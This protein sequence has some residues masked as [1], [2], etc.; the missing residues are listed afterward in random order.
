MKQTTPCLSTLGRKRKPE[1]ECRTLPTD[2]H[3]ALPRTSLQD[4]SV[5]Q[6]RHDFRTMVTLDR[7]R[8][9]RHFSICAEPIFPPPDVCSVDSSNTAKHKDSGTTNADHIML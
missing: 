6:N 4:C 5:L 8:T 7:I 2:L 1:L 3:H 9:G